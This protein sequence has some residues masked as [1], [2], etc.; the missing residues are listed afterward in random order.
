LASLE[1]PDTTA[2]WPRN[3]SFN[4]AVKQTSAQTS[5]PCNEGS[6]GALL[7]LLDRISSSWAE[8]SASISK[9]ETVNLERCNDV[10]ALARVSRVVGWRF[11]CHVLGACDASYARSHLLTEHYDI[12]NAAVIH[13]VFRII[14]AAS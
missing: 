14:L 3:G 9:K 13:C 5:I 8:G 4:A 11:E 12:A 6:A 2:A 10:C 7:R 1:S